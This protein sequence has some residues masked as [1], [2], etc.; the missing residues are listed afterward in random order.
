MTFAE[1]CESSSCHQ[2]VD[3]GIAADAGTVDDHTASATVS[4]IGESVAIRRSGALGDFSALR[5]GVGW[6]RS[7]IFRAASTV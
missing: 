3:E 2:F 6:P 5:I 1:W 4:L 7:V